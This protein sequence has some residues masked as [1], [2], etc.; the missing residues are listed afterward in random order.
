MLYRLFF[1]Q[2]NNLFVRESGHWWNSPLI[3]DFIHSRTSHLHELKICSLSN[4][5]PSLYRP[6][7][8]PHLSIYEFTQ[9]NVTGF[10]WTERSVRY[11]LFSNECFTYKFIYLDSYLIEGLC[12]NN[13]LQNV[14]YR[15]HLVL[16][17]F[18]PFSSTDDVWRLSCTP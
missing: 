11:Y 5:L 18:W 17:Q 3:F 8:Q 12:W 1:L 15:T 9:D 16:L 2:K 13:H 4:E 14:I 6:V 7:G 10:S